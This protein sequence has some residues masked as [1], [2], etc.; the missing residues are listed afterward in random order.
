MLLA[1]ILPLLEMDGET[2]QSNRRSRVKSATVVYGHSLHPPKTQSHQI[3]KAKQSQVWLVLGWKE[4]RLQQE[5][6]QATE[7]CS[8]T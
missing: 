8:V 7:T 3:L 2:L 5:V 1:Q 6:G 4:L